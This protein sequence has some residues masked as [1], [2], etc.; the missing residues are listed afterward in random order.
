[1]SKIQKFVNKNEL[2]AGIR[3]TSLS[4]D[5]IRFESLNQNYDLGEV[6]YLF[7]N[8]EI[9]FNKVIKQFEYALNIDG[10][11]NH[12][13]ENIKILEKEINYDHN[14]VFFSADHS[15]SGLYLSAF[16]KINPD[17]KIGVVWIDA[18]GDMHSPYTSPSGNMHGMTLSIALRED[19]IER[20]KR[21][22]PIEVK[23]K[24]KKLQSLSG[25]QK[26]LEYSNLIFLGIRDLEEQEEFILKKNNVE[27]YKSSKVNS[28]SISE[29]VKNIDEKLKDC[30]HIFI[31]FDVDSMDPDKVSYGTGTPV[32]NGLNLDVTK[33]LIDRLTKLKKKISFEIVEINPLLDSHNNM[34][35]KSLE[36]IKIV[37]E[38]LEK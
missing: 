15:S 38:N 34:A 10:I 29:I 27:Y 14:Q 2:G 20:K 5:A 26:A 28:E 4:F 13:I 1:M 23:N 19:N 31:S 8:N 22:L 17:A 9:L 3:G 30:D 37:F 12:Y 21:E 16:K 24:W 11:L 32:K 18:H 36:L 6:F 35:R 7:A 25:E 33:E